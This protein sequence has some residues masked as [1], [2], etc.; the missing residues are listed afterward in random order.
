MKSGTCSATYGTQIM[1][2]HDELMTSA[3]ERL[4]KENNTLYDIGE[5]R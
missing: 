1:V 3:N 4:D 2:R 5:I